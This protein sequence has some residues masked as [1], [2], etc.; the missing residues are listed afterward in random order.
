MAD[1]Q[2]K[3]IRTQESF[4]RETKA[5]ELKA[6]K[7]RADISRQVDQHEDRISTL[8]QKVAQLEQELKNKTDQLKRQ[9][10]VAESGNAEQI[11]KLRVALGN[12]ADRDE[13]NNLKTQ[14]QEQ[15][16]TN[17]PFSAKQ[18]VFTK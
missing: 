13:V 5:A 17:M 18:C 3:F 16:L 11:Q 14:L 8:E 6:A 9:I 1:Q 10:E 12:K 2:G 15:I 7:D 4:N